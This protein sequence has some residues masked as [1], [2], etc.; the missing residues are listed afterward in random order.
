MRDPILCRGE[1][2]F[3]TMAALDALPE[4]SCSLPTG[5]SKGKRWKRSDEY[6]LRDRGQ[7][8]PLCW[9]MG[10]Y[11]DSFPDPRG[12]RFGHR[13]RITWRRILVVPVSLRGMLSADH[14]GIDTWRRLLSL[15]AR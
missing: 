15:P 8:G 7:S 1:F 3:M 6:E 12:E 11:G 13:V 2:T 10:E 14:G 5:T 9:W 4:Y